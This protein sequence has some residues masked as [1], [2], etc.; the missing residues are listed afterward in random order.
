MKKCVLTWGDG[1]INLMY[2]SG[3]G[4]SPSVQ[5]PALPCS[6]HTVKE[7]CLSQSKFRCQA[8]GYKVNADINSARNILVAGLAVLACVGM[9][10][11]GHPLKQEYTSFYGVEDV[12]ML[13][14]LSASTTT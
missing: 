11:S 7:N 2:W 6:G 13:P 8:C 10:Q 14:V 9:V 5:K 4:C 12:K 3:A 1:S